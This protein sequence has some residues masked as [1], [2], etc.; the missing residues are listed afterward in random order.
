MSIFS[1]R[2]TIKFS[3]PDPLANG[4]ADEIA[5]E[6]KEADAFQTLDDVSSEELN[7]HWNAIVKDIKKDPAW[8]NFNKD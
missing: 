5:A 1:R 6:Q 7:K 8:A 3:T 2:R 4:L